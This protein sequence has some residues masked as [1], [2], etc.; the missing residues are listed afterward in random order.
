M[1]RFQATRNNFDLHV[2]ILTVEA[3]SRGPH[4]S[5]VALVKY[6]DLYFKPITVIK[7][8]FARLS[9]PLTDRTLRYIKTNIMNEKG[10]DSKDTSEHGFFTKPRDQNSTIGYWKKANM[11]PLILEKSADC[12]RKYENTKTTV[13]NW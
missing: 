12:I 9:L 6:E 4:G 13:L 2:I 3:V 5:R 7:E 1:N 11:D 10:G 8:T